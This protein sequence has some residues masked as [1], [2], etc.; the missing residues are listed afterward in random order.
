MDDIEELARKLMCQFGLPPDL[1]SFRWNRSLR[2]I[3]QCVYPHLKR[4]GRIELSR[5]LCEV[6]LIDEVEDTIRHEIAHALAGHLPGDP[7]GPAWI[8]ACKL[9]GCRPEPK[10][11]TACKV[12]A[13][14]QGHCL[15]CKVSHQRFKRPDPKM[16]YC[17]KVCKTQVTFAHV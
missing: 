17:C 4:P 3:G 6:N 10:G 14:W 5:P 11:K 15:F 12:A 9:T 2:R 16:K 13:P 1:W 8:A 7:H